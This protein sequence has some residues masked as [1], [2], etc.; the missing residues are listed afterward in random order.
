MFTIL[1]TAH[2][3]DVPMQVQVSGSQ[4]HATGAFDVPYVKWGMKDP[5]NFAIKVHKEVQI[6]LLLVGSLQR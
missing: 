1:G 2:E 3:I 5:S 4:F 6:E